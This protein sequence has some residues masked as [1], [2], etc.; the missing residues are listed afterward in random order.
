MSAKFID[1]Y[2]A[3]QKIGHSV[4]VPHGVWTLFPGEN[5]H[6][7]EVLGDQISL[8]GDYYS[9]EK[10][11]AAIEWYVDQLGGSVKWKESK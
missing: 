9:L 1:K 2:N 10:A 7:L 4:E 6:N 11:R 8:G 3:I 5:V